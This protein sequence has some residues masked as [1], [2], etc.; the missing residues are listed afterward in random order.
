MGAEDFKTSIEINGYAL[1]AAAIK[2]VF[3]HPVFSPLGLAGK[4]YN[5]DIDLASRWSATRKEPEE[6]ETPKPVAASPLIA[7]K[8]FYL[9]CSHTVPFSDLKLEE[10]GAS[11]PYYVNTILETITLHIALPRMRKEYDAIKHYFARALLLD[12]VTVQIQFES[13]GETIVRQQ[14]TCPALERINESLLEQVQDDYV[15][16]EIVQSQDSIIDVASLVKKAS[17]LFGD[18]EVIDTNW[19][20]A[21]LITREKTRHY[22]HLLYLSER[23]AMK[24]HLLRATGEPFSF[25]FL[26]QTEKNLYVVWETHNTKEATYLWQLQAVEAADRALEIDEIIETIK[27]LRQNKKRDYIRQ[28]VENYKRIHHVYS[29]SDNGFEKWKGEVETFVI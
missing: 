21:K 20:L 1:Q 7:D 25:I 26:I 8:P 9:N 6:I 22:H 14:V 10:G 27:M 28:K 4:H 23:H 12:K 17:E 18:V 2:R 19:L 3:I 16:S 5:N 15:Q 11:F 29:G 13:R 24:L